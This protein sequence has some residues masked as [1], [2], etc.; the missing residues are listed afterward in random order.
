[1]KSALL[2]GTRRG[3]FRIT[4]RGKEVLASNPE[5]IDNRFLTQFEEFRQFTEKSAQEPIEND[6]PLPAPSV[7]QTRD[8]P[9]KNARRAMMEIGRDETLMDRIVGSSF[10]S[11]T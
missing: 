7:G 8:F 10:T 9:D 1:V 6:T 11:K 2:E 3:H 5:R 4:A